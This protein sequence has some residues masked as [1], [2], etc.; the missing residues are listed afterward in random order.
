MRA[1]RTFSQITDEFVRSVVIVR[2]GKQ[3]VRLRSVEI[4]LFTGAREIHGAPMM[5]T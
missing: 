3:P 2:M 1:L 5:L 4:T